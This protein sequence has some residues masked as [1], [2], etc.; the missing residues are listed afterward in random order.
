MRD[1]YKVLGLPPDSDQTAIK[2][3]YRELAKELHPDRNGGNAKKTERF[4][5]VSV[6]FGVLSHEESRAKYDSERSTGKPTS[7]FFGEDFNDLMNRVKAEGF[8]AGLEDFF[9]FAQNFQASTK[10]HVQ[11]ASEKKGKVFGEKTTAIFDL[12]DDIFDIK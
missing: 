9:E 8:G 4:K 5:E 1:L 7:S 12:L 2:R 3:R 11:K 6:A 10:K